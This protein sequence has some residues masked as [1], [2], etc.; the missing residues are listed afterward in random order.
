MSQQ[1]TKPTR[2]ERLKNPGNIR[3]SASPWIGR[4]KVQA[5]AEF[6]TFTDPV[7]GIRALAKVLLTYYRVHKRKT[8]RQIVE[9]WAPSHENPTNSY[10]RFVAGK[11]RVREDETLD[12]T[13]P[14]VLE[15]LVK[16]IIAF[17][18]GR[19]IYPDDLVRDGVQ[20]ALG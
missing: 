3:H 19:N 11:M 15:R 5:D 16:A 20:R 14:A 10:A 4:A 6:V 9:R 1:P 12:L 17:E 18:N 13:K 2:G 7:Y 8:V